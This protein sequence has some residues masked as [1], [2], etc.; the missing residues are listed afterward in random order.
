MGLKDTVSKNREIYGNCKVLSP[1]GHLMFRCDDKK[2][3]WYLKRNLADVVANDPLVIQLNFEPKGYGNY[4]SDYGLHEMKNV[5]VNCG[6]T[7]Y[8]TRHHVVPYC[9]R[10]Y[11]PIEIK[12]HNFHDVLLLC[13]ECHES[14]ENHASDLKLSIADELECPINGVINTNN[15]DVIK[16]KKMANCLLSD[17]R[18]VPKKKIR[19]IKKCLKEEF[20]WNR[21][22]RKRLIEICEQKVIRH[23]ITHGEMV[24]S[25]I[26]DHKGF[27]KRWREHFV[28]YNDCNYMPKN[29]SVD[30]E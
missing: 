17:R 9:Y 2:A 7:E 18:N 19:Y 24:A 26:E 12:S 1:G 29:W 5:C 27:M 14:Y 22:T 25:K 4:D 30:Y 28:E 6:A 13:S 10:R 16:I 23:K 11:F 21:V 15:K 20:G 3:N 8:L